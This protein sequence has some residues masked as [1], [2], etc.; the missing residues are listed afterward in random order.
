MPV[1]VLAAA[2][3]WT[4]RRITTSVRSRRSSDVPGSAA[5]GAE[6]VA[7]DLRRACGLG[8]AAHRLSLRARA[9]DGTGTGGADDAPRAQVRALGPARR[10]HGRPQPQPPA[11]TCGW[12]T[13]SRTSPPWMRSATGLSR[14]PAPAAVWKRARSASRTCS[15]W[16]RGQPGVSWHAQ[17]IGAGGRGDP[18]RG[19]APSGQDWPSKGPAL[20]AACI[21]PWPIVPAGSASTTTQL[22]RSPS[23]WNRAPSGSPT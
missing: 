4:L 8:R 3:G 9:S 2:Q 10:D 15:G 11:R 14:I 20:L 13:P 7:D 1:V 21:M 23:C 18:G 5:R 19:P 16:Q 17:G 22:S 6:V 12:C